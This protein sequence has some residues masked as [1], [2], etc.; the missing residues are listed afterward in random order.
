MKPPEQVTATRAEL[1][2]LLAAALPVLAAAQ[3]QLLEAVLNECARKTRWRKD[4]GWQ[5]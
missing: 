4:Q 2:A 5:W 3:Y 1:D